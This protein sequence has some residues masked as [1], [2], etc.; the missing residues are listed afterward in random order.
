MGFCYT[1]LVLRRN[2][3]MKTNEIIGGLRNRIP[4]FVVCNGID[5]NEISGDVANFIGRSADYGSISIS[6]LRW[7]SIVEGYFS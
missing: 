3:I 6:D 1:V 7:E 5:V 4:A 2:T